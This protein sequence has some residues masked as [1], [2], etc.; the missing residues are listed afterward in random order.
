M[1]ADRESHQ[2]HATLLDSTGS[3]LTDEPVGPR[4]KPLT[5]TQQLPAGCVGQTTTTTKQ[6]NGYRA[7][8]VNIH[9]GLNVIPNS[10]NQSGRL[11][12]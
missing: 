12:E 6:Q 9:E 3:G 5:R 7:R 11:S 8:K 2:H 4:Q 10:I 1:T